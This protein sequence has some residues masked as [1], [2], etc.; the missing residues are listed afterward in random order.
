[1]QYEFLKRYFE[2]FMT[3]FKKQTRALSSSQLKH[4]RTCP[5]FT[6]IPVHKDVDYNFLEQ[7]PLHVDANEP[8]WKYSK[9]IP[10][11]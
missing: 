11:V 2:V 10:L 6:V 1:V 4:I 7:V 8:T 9:P 3:D 5:E